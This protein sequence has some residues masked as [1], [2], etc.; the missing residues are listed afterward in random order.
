MTAGNHSWVRLDG[1]GDELLAVLREEAHEW[2]VAKADD[3]PKGS[4]DTDPSKREV[5][6][7]AALGRLSSGLRRGEILV[8]DPMLRE[9]AARTTSETR[10]LDELKEE[11]DRVR[12]EHE[13]WTALLAHLDAAPHAGAREDEDP[14][15]EPESIVEDDDDPVAS[16]PGDSVE[17]ELAGRLSD[18]QLRI[19][20]GAVTGTLASRTG[21]LRHLHTRQDPDRELREIAALA[22]LAFWLERGSVEVP[23]HVVQE[24]A[25]ALAEGVAEM[26][27]DDEIR[28]RYEEAVAEEEAVGALAAIFSDHPPAGSSEP[29]SEARP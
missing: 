23:D 17:I 25:G 27:E 1:I 12:A 14:D 28:E 9:L 3:L 19:V 5:E 4:E 8:P 6:E 21:D 15:A 7:V 22:R 10:R 29:S 13:G 2:L 20:R 18:D 26:N 16:A 11:Y 24:V